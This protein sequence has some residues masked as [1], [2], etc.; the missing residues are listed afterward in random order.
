M[1]FFSPIQ[2][3]IYYKILPPAVL[4]FSGLKTL[5]TFEMEL[6][7]LYLVYCLDLSH[8]FPVEYE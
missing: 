2:M 1:L 8:S 3:F 5:G 6:Q 7:Y 4:F